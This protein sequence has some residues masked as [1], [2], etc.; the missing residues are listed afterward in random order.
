MTSYNNHPDSI[1]LNK[2]CAKVLKKQGLPRTRAN[3]D[4][5]KFKNKPS[6]IYKAAKN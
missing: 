2:A 1:K 6:D 4:A 5:L 3:I